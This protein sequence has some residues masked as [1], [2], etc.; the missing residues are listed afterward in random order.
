MPAFVAIGQTVE[1]AGEIGTLKAFHTAGFL[2]TDHGPFLIIDPQDAASAVRP[3]KELGD[4][5]FASRR[6]LLEQLLAQEPVYQYGS[7]FQREAVVKSLDASDR[8]LRSPS[9][10]AFDLSLEP[11]ESFDRYNTGRFGQGCLLARRL[12]EAGARYVE[13]TSEYIPVR[14]LGHARERPPARRGH[15]EDHRPADRAA[16]ARPRRARPARPDAGRPGQRVQPRRGDRRQGRQGSQRPGHQH[17]RHHAGAETLRHAPPLHGGRFG[18]DVRRRREEGV[19]LR[20]DGRRAALHDHRAPDAGRRPARHDLPRARHPGRSR[21]HRS[22]TSRVCHA[23]RQG[24]PRT[25][26]PEAALSARGDRVRSPARS[27]GAPSDRPPACRPSPAPSPN[28]A[29]A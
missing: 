15:E 22:E 13:V 23:G 29:R 21:L 9:A 12:V 7:A 24:R 26:S 11:K 18:A 5:R 6:Q 14:L 4:Q 27:A 10:K 1:G 25:C 8:L 16:R 19:R 2:G 20:Q 3:P 17:P 28:T